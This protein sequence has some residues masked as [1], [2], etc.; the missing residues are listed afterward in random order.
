MKRKGRPN[1][2]RFAFCFLIDNNIREIY[3]MTSYRKLEESIKQN[4]NRKDL[5][6]ELN[7]P[8]KESILDFNFENDDNQLEDEYDDLFEFDINTN[9][10]FQF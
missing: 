6:T 2:T 4:N 10:Y 9:D 8:K 1:K 7:Q 3:D 5:E